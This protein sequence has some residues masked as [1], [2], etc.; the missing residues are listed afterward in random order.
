MLS[1]N[2]VRR[3]FYACLTSLMLYTLAFG[4]IL[5]RPLSLGFL[6]QQIDAKLAYAASINGPKLVILAGSNG[7]Y[8]HRCE[9][10]EPILAMPCVNGGVAVGVGL[11]Y[12]F[13]RWRSQLRAHDVVYLP[14]EEAQYVRTQSST[15]VG[16][17]AA[18]MFRHDWQTLARLSPQRW[19]A[20]LFS[21][22]V[23]AAL[24]D[25]IETTLLI[26]HFHDPRTEVTGT[27]NA[28]GDHLGH[29]A[30]L[31]EKSRAVLAAAVPYHSSADQ[32]RSGY[33]T[34]LIG[35]FL[36]WASRHGVRIIGGLPTE[37]VDAPM[38]ASTVEA[39]RSVYLNN[40]AEFL[41]LPNLSRYPR[42]AF[43]DAPEHLNETWQIV[44][45]KLLA[46]RLLQ[47]LA[48]IAAAHPA[49]PAGPPAP[50]NTPTD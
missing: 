35:Q 19:I 41:A 18:I 7:P 50:H 44:H 21:F 46:E 29:T 33:G 5:N 43:F 30:K 38:P 23:R 48:P 34:E 24:M 6:Q 49:D 20:A 3:L 42:S 2:G 39:I 4:F 26:M 10:I 47:H 13:A 15:N 32:I 25:P 22:D 45:S 8:S 14:M 17:D 11:D 37:F 31:A 40:G 36:H 16:P 9:T 28:W 12:L 27:T 1:H